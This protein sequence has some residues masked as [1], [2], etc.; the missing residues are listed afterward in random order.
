MDISSLLGLDS[1]DVFT[2]RT[3][4]VS[5]LTG[6]ATMNHVSED[7][8]ND[9]DGQ[10]FA[11]LR[12]W[13]DVVLVG[14]QTVR[15]EDYSGVAPATD[16]SRPAPIAV[17][18]RSLDFDITSDFFTD[19][20][21]PPIL[22]VP[23]SS[24]DDQEL[25]QRIATIESA[26]AEVCDAGEG[27]AQNYI[28]VLKDRG[29]KRVLCEGGPGMIGQLVDIDAI[30]QMYL[31]LDPHLSTG[32]ETPMATFQGEHSHRRMQLENVAADHDGTVFLRY[33]RAR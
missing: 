13:A 26:G 4:M 33:S 17:P 1:G 18:S 22:L 2:I 29:F 27:T 9:T 30:D 21:T 32:V 11:A 5:T 7:M 15:A 25:A 24:W 19:F 3:N 31:T 20:T 28:S 16:G 6:S 14:A 10:L 12:N 23:H 8:G